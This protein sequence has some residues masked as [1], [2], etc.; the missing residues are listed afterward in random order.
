MPNNPNFFGAVISEQ[1]FAQ[2]MRKFMHAGIML[3]F[4]VADSNYNQEVHDGYYWLTQFVEQ[5]DPV[6]EK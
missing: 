6:L 4:E 5:I 2:Y 1:E 3:N